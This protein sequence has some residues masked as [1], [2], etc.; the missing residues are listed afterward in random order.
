[1][2]I[3]VDKVYKSHISHIALKQG[4]KHLQTNS[5]AGDSAARTRNKHWQEKWS[6]N[7]KNK[8]ESRGKLRKVEEGQ[9]SRGLELRDWVEGGLSEGLWSSVSTSL[10]LTRSNVKSNMWN[11]WGSSAKLIMSQGKI[12]RLSARVLVALWCVGFG[13]TQWQNANH[14]RNMTMTST[15]RN[16]EWQNQHWQQQLKTTTSM[17]ILLGEQ[18][19]SELAISSIQLECVAWFGW[20]DM[21]PKC[22]LV[23]PQKVSGLCSHEIVPFSSG[24]ALLEKC[25][26]K[27]HWKRM[28]LL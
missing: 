11:M 21:L 28:W 18:I 9:G 14:T 4:V 22:P 8:R 6:R 12:G 2:S 25:S 16:A 10:Q 19:C 26:G 7:N 24:P 23:V 5:V 13:R 15:S 27:F 1:M 20:V 3:G 17:Q